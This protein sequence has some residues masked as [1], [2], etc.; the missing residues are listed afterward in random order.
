MF[1]AGVD[2]YVAL[3][4]VF[5]LE[6]SSSEVDSGYKR[7]FSQRA[8]FRIPLVVR[9]LLAVCKRLYVG[10]PQ[11]K[12]VQVQMVFGVYVGSEA[13]AHYSYMFSLEHVTWRDMT[14]ATYSRHLQVYRLDRGFSG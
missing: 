1:C 12:I 6:N 11:P 7:R 2:I 5:F 13:H 3:F 14:R 8:R 4:F 9:F 10:I